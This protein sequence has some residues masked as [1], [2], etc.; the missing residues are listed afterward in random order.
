MKITKN[1]YLI[2]QEDKRKARDTHTPTHD[3][4]STTCVVWSAC[5][6]LGSKGSLIHGDFPRSLTRRLC[7]AMLMGSYKG[8]TAV[9]DCHCPSDMALCICEV[10]ARPWCTCAPW[11]STIEI[12]KNKCLP[13]ALI[14][15]LLSKCFLELL[16]FVIACHG[17]N[18]LSSTRFQRRVALA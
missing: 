14:F 5:T 7:H 10:L 13:L 6:R 2:G 4:A 1:S 12:K 11:H 17:F 8:E 3:L 18:S 9:H 15:N 16:S